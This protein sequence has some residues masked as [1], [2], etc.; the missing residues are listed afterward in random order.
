MLH[1]VPGPD[2]PLLR[3]VPPETT[4][5]SLVYQLAA[6]FQVAPEAGALS[7]NIRQTTCGTIDFEAGADIVLLGAGPQPA[8]SVPVSRTHVAPHPRTG[9]PTHFV[10]FPMIP[11][12]V[13][14]GSGAN[15][16]S[17]FAIGQVVGHPVDPPVR[18]W[19][20]IPE[21]DR[22]HAFELVQLAWEGG[23]LV[24]SEPERLDDDG[25]LPG[26]AFT[27]P[28]LGAALPDGGGLL[29]AFT[30]QRD[31]GRCE[32]GVMRWERGERGWRPVAF[33]PVSGEVDT[34]EPTV[35]RDHDGALLFTARGR[36][37]YQEALRLWRSG[38]G[39]ET[40]ELCIELPRVLAAAPVTLNMGPGGCP[41]IAGNPRRERDS[42]GRA[43]NSIEMRETLQIWPLTKDRRGVHDPVLVRDCTRFGPAP[44][45]S[46]WRADH[47]MGATLQLGDDAPRHWVFYRV[48]EQN[49]CIGDAPAT[50]LTG[51][52]AAEL[53]LD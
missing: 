39:G 31:G 44:N 32:T 37:A 8:E 43:I 50:P 25:F 35:V 33:T 49:E 24:A 6:P 45:G 46:I 36:Q 41:Y 15:G 7:V 42:L 48:L 3:V 9:K 30:A 52:F 40:W 5:A 23:R 34:F 17:G 2:E 18:F 1:V 20:Q 14:A 27:G 12:F 51:T 11:G 53:L 29:M 21:E 28:S 16:G 26:W 4:V 38:D 19:T 22:L 47:P 10:Q 13:P